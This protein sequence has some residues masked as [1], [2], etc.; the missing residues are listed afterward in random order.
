[1]QG[2]Y[3]SGDSP[4][5][6]GDPRLTT[7]IL[8]HCPEGLLSISPTSVLPG[9]PCPE[10]GSRSCGAGGGEGVL[11]N[12]W[13]IF[14]RSLQETL[15][16]K[17]LQEGGSHEPAW[18]LLTN[19][20]VNIKALLRTLRYPKLTQVVFP[21]CVPRSSPV[22]KFSLPVVWATPHATSR[23]WKSSCTIVH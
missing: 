15:L 1:M 17:R 10:R 12:S 19:P 2:K 14:R 18:P 6:Y 4:G 13:L 3:L 23:S 20:W 16:G 11:P 5:D 8:Q 7:L 21:R 22:T 9:L